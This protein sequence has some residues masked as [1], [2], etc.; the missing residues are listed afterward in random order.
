MNNNNIFLK[1]LIKEAINE[2]GKKLNTDSMP[3]DQE[4]FSFDKF[5]DDYMDEPDEYNPDA[6]YDEEE[7]DKPK[8]NIRNGR[9]LTKATHWDKA[10]SQR[11]SALR[12]ITSPLFDKMMRHP[13]IEALYTDKHLTNPHNTFDGDDYEPNMFGRI[14]VTGVPGSTKKYGEPVFIVSMYNIDAHDVHELAARILKRGRTLN[15][16]TASTR[17]KRGKDGVTMVVP[18]KGLDMWKEEEIPFIIDFLKEKN[19]DKNGEIK[20]GSDEDFEN[21]RSY[22]QNKIFTKKDVD[23]F[24]F[25]VSKNFSELLKTFMESENDEEVRAIIEAYARY[26]ISEEICKD[27]N[28]DASYGHILSWTNVK[29]IMC[30]GRNATFILPEKTWKRCFGRLVKPTAKPFFINVPSNKNWN[31]KWKNPTPLPYTYTDPKD[32]STKTVNISSTEDILDI[33]YEGQPY[34]ELSTQQRFK[35][36]TLANELN[37]RNT[38][39]IPEYD[40]SDTV[41]DPK[42]NPVDVFNEEIG[43]LNNLTGELNAKAKEDFNSKL[44]KQKSNL[45][46]P[47]ETVDVEETDAKIAMEM[48]RTRYALKNLSAF[49]K[50][51][52]IHVSDGNGDITSAFVV[53]LFNAAKRLI[54][55]KIGVTNPTEVERLANNI[56]YFICLYLRIGLKHIAGIRIPVKTD[57]SMLSEI[58]VVVAVLLNA[59]EKGPKKT[60]D[61]TYKTAL[62][63]GRNYEK[64]NELY[65]KIHEFFAELNKEAEELELKQINETF[66]SLLERMDNSKN[67]LL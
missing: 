45:E 52:G 62:E 47:E 44:N 9:G 51:Y 26:N 46:N 39:R 23:S 5:M 19:I 21:L 50:K 34:N 15:A 12:N 63:E 4:N 2:L 58:D 29:T 30:S 64:D 28:I 37:V 24:L 27:L 16:L 31:G 55:K 11:N 35:V 41:W 13:K 17:D 40:V 60:D 43:L 33:F 67:N 6:E 3:G 7:V 65:D 61:K 38:T 54:P 25:N 53:T 57:S 66:Y 8:K 49:A 20:Y 18:Q 36:N 32:G 59:I 42:L 22:L 1:R 14:Q 56:V 48:H 10:N